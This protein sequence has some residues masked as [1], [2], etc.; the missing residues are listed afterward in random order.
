M[1]YTIN[2]LKNSLEWYTVN[3]GVM[4]GKSIGK[5]EKSHDGLLF[6]G[7]T[8]LENNGGFSSVRCKIEK[9]FQ[10]LKAVEL[11][12]KSDGRTYE[13]ICKQKGSEFAYRAPFKTK[14]GV[15]TT[16]TL[17]P[18][19]F[20]ASYRGNKIDAPSL[21]LIE[22]EEVGVILADGNPGKFKFQ[23]LDLSLIS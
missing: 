3:D 19:D 4:G 8:S 1:E 10:N 12:F 23:L 22:L 5:V 17:T 7:E 14:S 2:L 16:V 15:I 11:Q 20:I 18:A 6:Y 13:V 9:P 21:G